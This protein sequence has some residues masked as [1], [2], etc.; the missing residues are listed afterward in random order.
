[1][2]ENP[3]LKNIPLIKD[4][5]QA[6]KAVSDMI[7]G[8]Y[9]KRL[10]ANFKYDPKTFKDRLTADPFRVDG[11]A[12]ITFVPT[13]ETINTLQDKN[14][15]LT[16]T[17]MPSF[18]QH[19]M[20]VWQISLTSSF[21]NV[22][23]EQETL[24]GPLNKQLLEFDELPFETTFYFR[25]KYYTNV[26]YTDWSNTVT[27]R[28]RDLVPI[29][30][31]T[32]TG[33]ILNL[34][35]ITLHSSPYL[36]PD[37]LHTKTT[38]EI[39]NSNLFTSVIHNRTTEDVNE[40][41]NLICNL[42]ADLITGYDYFIRVKFHNKLIESEWSE[43]TAIRISK[44]GEP[45]ISSVTLETP[46]TFKVV[47]SE[48]IHSLISHTE[49]EWELSSAIDFSTPIKITKN[50]TD[51]L[52][53]IFTLDVDIPLDDDI[54]YYFRVRYYSDTAFSDWSE[55]YVLNITN[56]VTPIIEQIDIVDNSKIHLRASAFSHTLLTHESTSYQVSKSPDMSNP[57]IDIKVT[58]TLTE[59]TLIVDPIESLITYYCRVRYH[60]GLVESEWSNITPI[61]TNVP[62]PII[63]NV[64]LDQNYDFSVTS[65]EFVHGYLTHTKTLWELSY[66]NNFLT[67][68]TFSDDSTNLTAKVIDVMVKLKP[69]TNYYIRNKYK[70]DTLES[71]YSEP[72]LFTTLPIPKPQITAS[73][74][75]SEVKT[76]SL[77]GSVF[78]YMDLGHTKSIWEISKFIDFNPVLESKTIESPED[79]N[80]ISFVV[81]EDTGE[82]DYYFRLKHFS[83]EFDSVWSD[84]LLIR[85][86]SLGAIATPSISD[87]GLICPYNFYL[88]S[89][90]FEQVGDITQTKTIWQICEND[91]FL[92]GDPTLKEIT[93][94][95]TSDQSFTS[96]LIDAGLVEE[97]KTYFIRVKY[98]SE[99]T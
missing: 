11:F 27:I 20:S 76:F 43:P 69:N 33:E 10:D 14:F 56:I 19:T 57:I 36:H 32:I 99:P 82:T 88:E 35:K 54:T 73:A 63:T 40:L 84:T 77:T 7:D 48:Y 79:L 64:E 41:T 85:T 86:P 93:I 21:T 1:M 15:D 8:I 65:S 47:S 37:L 67:F 62:K 60:N 3:L 96:I 25:V 17:V 55:T 95:S 83:E 87:P 81:A 42:N 46:T 72:Y 51:L 91:Q 4:L 52:Q 34:R 50:S 75:T 39:S 31:P 89:S 90:S 66:L 12:R 98:L 26:S 24:I 16:A 59:A 5:T 97:G 38:W 80:H 30:K 58:D 71:E 94:D 70:C 2:S 13:I 29:P 9:E 6:G 44:I 92:V 22:V 68:I 78:N 74:Y 18:Y 53:T 28:T 61:Q 49:T 45:I 23:K